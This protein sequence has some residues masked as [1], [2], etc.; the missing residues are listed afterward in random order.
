[1]TAQDIRHKRKP[2][3]SQTFIHKP[4]KATFVVLILPMIAM[5]DSIRNNMRPFAFIFCALATA[6]LG[7]AAE[8]IPTALTFDIPPYVMNTGTASTGG[9]EVAILTFALDMF[10]DEFEFLPMSYDDVDASIGNGVA[11]IALSVQVPT[12]DSYEKD[13]VYYSYPAWPFHNYVFTKKADGINDNVAIKSIQDLDNYGPVFTWEGAVDELGEEFHEVFSNSD[14]YRPIGNQTEQMDL[15]WST[16][17]ALIV[18]DRTIFLT[19]SDAQMKEVFLKIVEHR[20]FDPQT[21]FGIGFKSE[22]M[23]DQFNAGLASM[24]ESDEFSY[25]DL[26]VEYGVNYMF[27]ES[28]VICETATAGTSSSSIRSSFISRRLVGIVSAIVLITSSRFW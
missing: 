11:E 5:I 13:G 2:L 17:D 21:T 25:E 20:L 6:R 15:F 18:I 19:Y 24:C 10:D 22:D 23:R 12:D 7:A 27:E 28:N 26:L 3:H 16:P 8:P 4:E 9:L 1:M 14:K